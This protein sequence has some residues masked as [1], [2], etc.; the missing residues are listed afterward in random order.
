M[1]VFVRVGEAHL[2][3]AARP[4]NVAVVSGAASAHSVKEA[5]GRLPPLPSRREYRRAR[6]QSGGPVESH[7]R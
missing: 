2:R 1:L 4:L 5:M 3:K 6:V 7:N